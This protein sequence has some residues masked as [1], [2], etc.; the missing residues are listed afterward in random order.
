M[1]ATDILVPPADE[2]LADLP[3]LVAVEAAP[4]V[5]AGFPF[6]TELSLEPLIDY[7]RAR[8]RDPNPGVARLARTVCEE[9]DQHATCRGQLNT[10]EQLDGIQGLIDML[11]LAVFPPAAA[12]AAIT[13]AI[14]PFQRRSFY[15]TSRFAEVMMGKD[16]T[17]KQP[18]NIDYATMERQMTQMAYLL[19]LGR[20]YG[21][22]IPDNQGSLIF[23]VP[24]YSI[25]LYRH[26][27]VNFDSSFVRVRVVGTKP[28]LNL[29]QVQHLLHNR[30]RLEL[31]YELLPPER[32]AFEGFNLLQLVDVTTQEILSELKYD[33]LERDVLQAADRL[34]Q[35]QE[36]LRVLF[37]RPAL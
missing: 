5:P 11:M 12:T 13:G 8:E 24:D 34:E 28:V 27:G 35:I 7:W 33:L 18:L 1:P 36:K 20:E 3:A 30:H 4:A 16:R 6:A 37:A 26:Y 22:E 19:I 31:W 17:I 15:Y 10:I 2:A 25:G 32:F 14:P 21:A 9:V 23:T 29:E